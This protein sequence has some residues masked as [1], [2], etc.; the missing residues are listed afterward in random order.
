MMK[1][2]LAFIFLACMI[3]SFMSVMASDYTLG[4]FGN[5]NMDDAVDEKDID[6]LKG[7]IE[8]KSQSTELADANYDGKIDEND[9]TQIELILAG[10]E[11]QLTVIDDT[12]TDAYPHGRPVTVKKP[13]KGIV[14]LNV[15]VPEALR[16]LGSGDT[17]IGISKTTASRMAFFSEI[18]ALPV[19]AED[20]EKI[21][22]L[23]P[24]LVLG[25]GGTMTHSSADIESKLNGTGIELV[26][27]DFNRPDTFAMD[28]ARLGYILNKRDR[29]E[30]FIEFY[31]QC[32]DPIKE[33]TQNLSNSLKPRVYIELW[34][35]YR[36]VRN[37]T[38]LDEVCMNSG[39]INIA[40][41]LTGDY[42][43]VDQE[44]VID[45]NPD[46]I[47][48]IMF[49]D[50]GYELGDPGK[51]EAIRDEII[52]RA[53]FSNITAVKNGNVFVIDR[54][55]GFLRHFVGVTYLSKLFHP[56]LFPELNPD[57][58]NKEYLEKFQEIP[59]MGFY[60]Y[61]SLGAN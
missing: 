32:M 35:P 4:I 49:N 52:N 28:I 34:N 57:E 25:Y 61:P 51:M 50:D 48:S 54:N 20:V 5:A 53:G 39:G 14:G 16:I 3:S 2:T 42:P 41:N 12:L 36:T 15:N 6:Y 21:I 59:Y 38:E 17:L 24:D 46:F 13:V 58:I 11:K 18:S 40:S 26:R 7:I 55:I 19:A 9:T 8:G 37:G 43:T 45:Q 44:W 27:L 30:E 60:I 22:S 33:I 29:A 1:A 56:D 10:T 23:D 31:D 47:I